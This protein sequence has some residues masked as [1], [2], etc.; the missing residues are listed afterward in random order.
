MKKILLVDDD[1]HVRRSLELGLRSLGYS[2]TPA[3]DANEAI[4]FIRHSAYDVMVTDVLMPGPNG[5][6]LAKQAHA[7][8]PNLPVIFMTAN[9]VQR[10]C[11]TDQADLRWSTK[12]PEQS[13]RPTDD[14][15]SATLIM[16]PFVLSELVNLFEPSES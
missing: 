4:H 12:A 3:V 16:K 6:E 13:S 10:Y 11:N 5:F 7:I 9:D 8:R 1:F 2:V 15:L 14:A